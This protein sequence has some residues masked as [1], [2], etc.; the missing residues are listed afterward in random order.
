MQ[1]SKKRG[2]E[3][4]SQWVRRGGGAGDEWSRGWRRRRS[5]CVQQV[6]GARAA[7]RECR[8]FEPWADGQLP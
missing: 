5:C 7:P 2:R 3:L 8:R 1:P 6:A 4:G